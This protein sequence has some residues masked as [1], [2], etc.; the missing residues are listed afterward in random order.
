MAQFTVVLMTALL[1]NTFSY[2]SA[3][4]VY[5]V[6]PA[7][8]SC[9]SCPHD[10]LNCTTLSEYAQEAELYFTS[11]TTMVFLPGDHIL[12]TNITVANVDR[13]TMCGESSSGKIATVICSG[14]V[15]LRFTRMVE[16]KMCSLAFT[17]CSRYAIIV[18]DYI[19]TPVYAAM[20][21][22]STQ[23]TELVN[24]SFH[25]NNGTALL[26]HNTNITLAGNTEFTHNRAC[27]KILLGG[28]IIAL[29]SNLTFTG[30]T[31]F[32]GNSVIA[33]QC[34][35][36]DIVGGGAIY[37]SGTVLRFSGTSNFINNFINNSGDGNGGGVIFVH[38][39]AVL[40]FSGT[41][42]F[43][44]NSADHYGGVFY[45]YE[46]TV[47]NFSGTNNFIN[48]SADDGGGAIAAGENIVLSFGGTNN[49]I[50]NSAGIYGGGV[51]LAQKNAVLSFSGT[52]HFTHG[53]GYLFR[54]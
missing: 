14:A 1:I 9:S 28:A 2:C 4:N 20:Y 44:N 41:N 46:N 31:T 17:S 12:D 53:W 24:C 6:I 34:P 27:G 49:F 43:I 11:N 5:C 25:D 38:E 39:N 52:S 23:Y 19:Y 50:N 8:T 40:S 51:I 48:N 37:T 36:T 29:S 22:Q 47:L 35:F 42:N 15:G 54:T 33:G 26:V 32:L 7:T 18:L 45:A 30:N 13:L 21:L 16:F 10:S 3:E